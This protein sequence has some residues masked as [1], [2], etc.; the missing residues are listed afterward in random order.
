MKEQPLNPTAAKAKS[1][2]EQPINTNPTKSL[3]EEQEVSIPEKVDARR[4]EL[5]KLRST[6]RFYTK[7]LTILFYFFRTMLRNLLTALLS[8]RKRVT[9]VTSL[10][11]VLAAGVSAYRTDGKHQAVFRSIETELFW[12][13]WWVMLGIASS[14]GLGTGLHT[15]VLFLGPHI[16]HV[17]VAAYR[18]RSLGFEVRGTDSYTCFPDE[19]AFSS[20]GDVTVWSIF[21]KVRLESILWGLGTALGEL[22]PYFVARAAAATGSDEEEISSM[23]SILALDPKDRTLGQRIQVVMYYVMKRMGFFGILLLASIP[24]PLFD[25]AGIIAGHFGVPF[26]TYFTATVIGKAVFK[27]NLQSLAIIVVFSEDTLSLILAELKQHLPFAYDLANSVLNDQVA[28]LKR[29]PSESSPPPPSKPANLLSYLWNSFLFSM[30]FYFVLSIIES[31]AL[32]ELRREHD[33]E[34]SRFQESLVSSLAAN[35]SPAEKST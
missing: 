33:A 20:F 16:A 17:T 15:F 4:R 13:G 35:S 11:A 6:T 2:A 18:C 28:K 3:P 30:I 32:S 24:N 31:L 26:T 5:Q 7:P 34:V 9:L 10:V 23:E 29:D 12:Y 22:P 1:P 14:I 25:L 21:R 8:L 27:A 19:D